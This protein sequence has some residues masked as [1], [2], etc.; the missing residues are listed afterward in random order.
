VTTHQ[1]ENEA[2]TLPDFR[3]LFEKSPDAIG[4]S[5]RGVHLFVNPA[6]AR[7]FGYGS[8]ADLIDK[9]VLSVVAPSSRD[10][11]AD[12]IERRARGEDVPMRYEALGLRSDG[13]EFDFEVNVST[14]DLGGR[15]NTLVILRDISQRKSAERDLAKMQDD[16]REREILL[17]RVLDANPSVIFVK[18]RNGTILLAN[19]ALA[20]IYGAS[21]KE[22][23]GRPHRELHQRWCMRA[24][25][26][27][28]WLADDREVIDTGRPFHAIESSTHRDGSLHWYSTRKVPLN[29]ATHGTCVLIVSADISE[30]KR[31]EDHVQQLNAELEQRVQQRT[32]ALAQANKELEAFSY[33]I[34]HDLRS[35]LR[36]IDGFAQMIREDHGSKLD[37]EAL[38]L[39]NV[40]SVNAQK[41]GDLIDDLLR[42]SRLNDAQLQHNCLDMRALAQSVVDEFRMLPDR[43]DMRVS[44]GELPEATGDS[45]M[46]R[47][48][49]VNLISNAVKF[50]RQNTPDIEIGGGGGNGE[51]VYFVRD[52]GVG[53]DAKYAHKLFHVFQ[54]LHRN[55][56]FAG[57]GVGLAIVER[58]IHR[59]GGRV[60]ADGKVNQGATFFFALPVAPATDPA[61]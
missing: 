53:F 31:A 8:P 19:E 17:R 15:E 35:P 38:R 56:E 9:P 11:I 54:R 6:Y 18:D 46:I 14:F 61:S 23:V 20:A 44:I 21:P 41:M 26:L 57:T 52:K 27:Q 43:A 32:A 48:V 55:E 58:I 59:H 49:L 36:A 13:T 16:L 30:Q 12:R 22:I 39:F 25:E 1:I 4:V 33:S 45:A 60:W 42:F 5:R 24:D 7:L 51:N 29:L 28:K 37:H 10:E 40:I 34:S 50:S 3:T 47:Q 2:T